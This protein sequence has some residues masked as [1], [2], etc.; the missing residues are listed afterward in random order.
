MLTVLLSFFVWKFVLFKLTAKYNQKCVKILN[1]IILTLLSLIV[2]F[3]LVK[4]IAIG[5]TG[6]L[7][8][9]VTGKCVA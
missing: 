9:P 2:F 4:I 1:V 5:G 7:I 6:C 3:I 8:D